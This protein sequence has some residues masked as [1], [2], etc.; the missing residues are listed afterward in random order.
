LSDQFKRRI[1]HKRYLALATGVPAAAS[2]TVDRPIGRH[3]IKR[4]QMAIRDDFGR[5]AQTKWRVLS[6]FEKPGA[7]GF[8]LLEA[9]PV[10]GRTHQIRVHFSALGHPIVGDTLYGYRRAQQPPLPQ[11]R[12]IHRQMLHAHHVSFHHPENGIRISVT[13]PMPPEMARLIDVLSQWSES[14]TS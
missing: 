4:K 11:L 6:R 9:E 10:T 8:T 14:G 2:G 5:P 3:D 1:V 12:R 7:A 13:A